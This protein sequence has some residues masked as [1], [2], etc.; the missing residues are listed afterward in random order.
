[1]L[2][3]RCIIGC[4]A[5]NPELPTR[6]TNVLNPTCWVVILNIGSTINDF[7]SIFLNIRSRS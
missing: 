7:K 3:D 1:M 5:Y 2:N 6:A 4:L